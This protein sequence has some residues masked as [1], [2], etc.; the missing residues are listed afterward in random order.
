MKPAINRELED[1]LYVTLFPLYF[2]L[3]FVALEILLRKYYV[4]M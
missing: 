3:M 2:T 4:S 1:F